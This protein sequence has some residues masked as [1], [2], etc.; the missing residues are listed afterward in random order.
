MILKYAGRD[1]TAAYEPIHPPDALDKHLPLEKH[2]GELNRAGAATLQHAHEHRK[3]SKDEI[4][5]EQ[6]RA[7]KPSIDRMLSLRDIEAS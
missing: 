7:R 6:A 4:R 5:V 1:A 3:K 2:L